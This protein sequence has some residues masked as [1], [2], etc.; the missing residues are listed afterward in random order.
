MQSLSAK[1]SLLRSLLK[2]FF[3][4]AFLDV[5]GLFASFFAI[6]HFAWYHTFCLMYIVLRVFVSCFVWEVKYDAI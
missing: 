4:V 6:E 2:S 1:V 5:S 3:D